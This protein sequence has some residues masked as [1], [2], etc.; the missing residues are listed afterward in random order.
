[1]PKALALA[2]CTAAIAQAF[3]PEKSKRPKE[4]LQAAVGRQKVDRF[5]ERC[6]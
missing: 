2:S 1:M 6:A 4:L 3:Q 5:A